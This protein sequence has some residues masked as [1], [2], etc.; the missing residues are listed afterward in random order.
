MWCVSADTL[1]T[2]YKL[3]PL[4]AH[5]LST[6]KEEL[7]NV[8]SDIAESVKKLGIRIVTIAESD[9]PLFLCEYYATPP[10]ILYTY[11]NLALLR[12]RKFAVVSSS[13]TSI[14]NTQVLRRL[15]GMLSEQ[16]LVAV[17]SHNTHPYQVAGLAAKSR[18]MPVI[19]VLDRGIF[20]AF[21]QGLQWEPIAQARIWNLN[22]DPTRDLVVSS[23]RLHDHWI[24]ANGRARDKLVFGFADIVVAVEIRSGGVMEQE[25]LH[26][27]RI[28]REVYVYEP[29]DAEIPMGNKKLLEKGY[30][31]VPSEW[32]HSLLSTLD[33]SNLGDDL[34]EDI[35]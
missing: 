16:G 33:W 18:N 26:A 24:G 5:Y 28:G 2:D 27:R 32:A 6:R 19:L 21:P 35:S 14:R 4:A 3:H 30:E 8:T 17:T 1:R 29:A 11:G 12:E 20:A 34:E 23:F 31:P 13:N 9:Y 25:C 15:A 10:P 7:L 22:F